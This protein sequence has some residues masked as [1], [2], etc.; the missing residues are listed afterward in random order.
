MQN[1]SKKAI[2][3]FPPLYRNWERWSGNEVCQTLAANHDMYQFETLR[4]LV[5]FVQVKKRENTQ[6]ELQS[7]QNFTTS[8]LG[9]FQKCFLQR[10]YKRK[11][12]LLSPIYIAL[13]KVG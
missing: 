8:D 11:L 7:N 13:K 4:D 1:F 10:E 3:L 2:I 6:A 9:S 5:P 12:P